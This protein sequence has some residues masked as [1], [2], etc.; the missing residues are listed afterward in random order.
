[1]LRAA[2]TLA[3]RAEKRKSWPSETPDAVR[4]RNKKRRDAVSEGRADKPYNMTILGSAE[5]IADFRFKLKDVCGKMGEEGGKKVSFREGIFTALSFWL[6]ARENADAARLLADCGELGPAGSPWKQR[7]GYSA[8]SPNTMDE[9]IFFTT[10]TAI[11]CLASRVH[12]HAIKCPGALAMKDP[13]M[14]L[15]HAAKVVLECGSNHKVMWDSSPHF[16]KRFLVNYRMAHGFFSS[17]IRPIQYQKICT[18]AG[19]GAIEDS[20]LR[21]HFEPMYS[22][23]VAKLAQESCALALQEEIALQSETDGDEYR[24]ISIVSDAR[25]CWR[26]NAQFSDVVFLGDRSHK[27]LRVETVSKEDIR[28]AQ[29]HEKEGVER[30]YRWADGKGLEIVVH[31]HDNNASVNKIVEDRA[32]AGHPTVNGN[33]TWHATKSIAKNMKTITSG[34]QRREGT[35]WFL[36]LADKAAAVKTH[37]YWA[38]KNCGG[39]AE[40]LRGF[41]DNIINHYKGDHSSCH[42]TSRCRVEGDDYVPWRKPIAN[43]KAEEK[44]REFLRKTVVY[45]KAENYVHAKDTHYVE[46]FNNAMLVYHDKRITFGRTNY[47]LRVNLAILDWNEHVDRAHTSV[48]TIEDARNPRKQQGKKQLVAKS[49]GFLAEVWA[50]FMEKAW[51]HGFQV[52]EED[53]AEAGAPAEDAPV[54]DGAVGGEPVDGPGAEDAPGEDGAVRGEPV[55]DAPGND[56]P[57]E[58]PRGRPGRGRRGQGRRGRGRARGRLNLPVDVH[59]PVEDGAVGGE[60]VEDAPGNDATLEEPRGRPGRGRRG[61][62]HRG[63]GRARGRL[64]IS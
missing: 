28:Y 19:I 52:P 64:V 22:E 17:G 44:L 14:M 23:V 61:Q 60:A 53:G 25:H 55:E 62:G 39:D 58:Q 57:L 50:Q 16:F 59:A 46:S 54:E 32:A 11:S 6:E 2:S 45:K 42:H 5:E 1:M 38:M 33:D 29:S 3:N 8:A 48:W 12:D 4:A 27:A 36:D 26:K 49:Y 63:R 40:R 35:T 56:A 37:I 9:P 21:N 13:P 31:A 15:G 43:P 51:N 47:L 30:F 20:N 18:A 24:G 10:P 41:I 7:N 34:A